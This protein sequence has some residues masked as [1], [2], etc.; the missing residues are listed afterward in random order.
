MFF[1]RVRDFCIRITGILP[2][3]ALRL[4]LYKHLFGMK[5]ADGARIEGGCTIWGPGR[6]SIGTG[7]VVNQGV[8]LDGRFPLTIGSH[9]SISFQ[10]IILTLEHDLADSEYFHAVGAPVSIG[11]H[12]FIGARAIV[13]PGVNIGEGAAVAAGAVVTTDVLPYTIVGGVPARR[14]GERPHDLRYQLLERPPLQD[15]RQAERHNG[16]AERYTFADSSKG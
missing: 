7:T 9:V 6:V 1:W 11:N 15:A 12:V 14:I 16:R 10:S 8:V 13:L 5:I 2:T 4:T 3:N